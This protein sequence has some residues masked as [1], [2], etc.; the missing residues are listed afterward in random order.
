M[1]E[2]KKGGEINDFDTLC[3]RSQLDKRG[4]KSK[5]L[6]MG[7]EFK[8]KN[9]KYVFKMHQPKFKVVWIAWFPLGDNCRRKVKCWVLQH[10]TL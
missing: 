5:E 10:S 4:I 1:G 7:A 8:L 3:L 6:N 2:K 9:S